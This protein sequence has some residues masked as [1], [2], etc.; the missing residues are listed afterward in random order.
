MIYF[1]ARDE[2]LSGRAA[3]G[4]VV[5][6]LRQFIGEPGRQR[7]VLPLSQLADPQAPSGMGLLQ[8][9]EHLISFGIAGT[10]AP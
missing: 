3:L 4:K 2:W 10:D 1:G 9:P 5:D 7:F 8:R 6:Q